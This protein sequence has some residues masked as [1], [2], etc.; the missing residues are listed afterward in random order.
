[1]TALVALLGSAGLPLAAGA[2]DLPSDG[3]ICDPAQRICYDRLGASLTQTRRYFGA[4]A[5]QDLLRS[6]SGRPP[7]RQFQ[8]SS[9]EVCDLQR[10]VCWDDGW[11]RSNVSNRLT[12]QL[13]GSPGSAGW[14]EG[15]AD[16][17]CELSQR[18]RMLFSGSCS[19]TRRTDQGGRSYLVETSDGRRYSFINLA[20]RLQLRDATGTWPVST[21]RWGN[22]VVFRWADLQLVAYRPQDR[23]AIPTPAGSSDQLLQQLID[24]LF[25]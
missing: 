18:G 10:L 12:R 24:G 8:F 25:R 4:L 16:R 6:L 11:R 3:V 22:A 13:F 17:I 14:P 2:L 1:M 15:Q 5:E 21:S 9:G 19:L 20:G 7:A 23:T